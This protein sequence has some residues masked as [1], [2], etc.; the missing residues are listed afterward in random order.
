M[1]DK[2]D[3]GDWLEDGAELDDLFSMEESAAVVATRISPEELAQ[4]VRDGSW[5]EDGKWQRVLATLEDPDTFF[6]AGQIFKSLRAAKDMATFFK[7]KIG[8]IPQPVAVKRAPVDEGADDGTDLA[9]LW[10]RLAGHVSPPGYAITLAGV[11]RLTREGGAIRITHRPMVMLASGHDIESEEARITLAWL[12]KAGWREAVIPREHFVSS[13]ALI[14]AIGALPE[15]PISSKN[16][17]DAIDFLMAYEVAN[18]AALGCVDYVSRL[19]WHRRRFATYADDRFSFYSNGEEIAKMAREVRSRGG[20][21]EW[22]E[23]AA[24]LCQAPVMRC[25]LWASVA[26]CLIFPLMDRGGMVVDFSWETSSGKTHALKL[27][28]SV[29]GSPRGRLISSWDDTKTATETRAGVLFDL[30]L[31]LDETKKADPVTIRSFVHAAC[32]GVMKGRGNADGSLRKQ[33]SLRTILLSTGEHPITHFDKITG[34]AAARCI[35][36]CADP[37]EIHGSGGRRFGMEELHGWTRA[38]GENYGLFGPIV[39]AWVSEHF[40]EV[41]AEHRRRV[42]EVKAALE[43]DGLEAGV[44][45][46]ISTNVAVLMVAEWA[47]HQAVALPWRQDDAH[48]RVVLASIVQEQAGSMARWRDAYWELMGW[49]DANAKRFRRKDRPGMEEPHG[50]WLGWD[51]DGC[52]FLRPEVARDQLDRMGYENARELL[53]QWKRK[54][55]LIVTASRKQAHTVKFDGH[56]HVKLRKPAADATDLDD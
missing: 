35:A 26:S 39:A 34:G 15:S 14:G 17:A 16:A 20:L 21:A 27:A 48:W 31:I 22:A 1:A 51:H 28:A 32:D 23:A 30:P 33:T 2:K 52:I 11:S 25:A 4:A 6:S 45:G 13:R 24:G 38:V 41:R 3:I 10:E 44:A 40:E 9:S 8:R 46:R 43:H 54:G 18:E 5:V 49:A 47:G 36:V 12:A 53:G 29:W 56:A 37:S 50:G 7:A 19:G 55:L 42:A